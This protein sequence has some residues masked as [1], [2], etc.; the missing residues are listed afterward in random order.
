MTTDAYRKTNNLKHEGLVFDMDGTL[1]DTLEG[2][3]KAFNGALK[4]LRMPQHPI[5]A[6][7]YF[8]GNGAEACA[9]KSLPEDSK[10]LIKPCVSLFKQDYASSWKETTVPYL[11]INKLLNDVSKFDV[12]I[13]VLSNKDDQLTQE[14]ITKSF[15]TINF[16]YVVGF[17]HK[18]IVELKPH[19]SGPNLIASKLGVRISC[20]A[21]IG[22]T[23]TDIET[24]ISSN[25]TPIG[26]SWGFRGREELLKA[27]A[28][29]VISAPEQLLG[30]LNA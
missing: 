20:L 24:A 22:D 3:A 8:I 6:Y 16:D 26:V 10:H 1:L 9:E 28:S 18:K 30:L 13:S 17:G 14:M 25:M 12:K 19:P 23:P 2:H 5:D 4:K 7:R 11:G 27:G 21:M 29:E 15:P